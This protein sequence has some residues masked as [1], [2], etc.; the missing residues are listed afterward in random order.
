MSKNNSTR[1]ACKDVY[2]AFLVR[3]AEFEGT[4]EIPCIKAGIFKPKK[5]ISFS[6]CTS[7]REFDSWV[8]FYEDDVV[9]ERLWKN[10]GK[11]LPVLSKFE[12]VISP[13]F[14]MYRDMPLVM[15]YWNIYRNHAIAAWLQESGIKVIPNIR[16]GDERTFD[17]ACLGIEKHGTIAIGSHGCIKILKDREIFISGLDAVVQNVEP[18]IVVVYGSAPGYIFDKYREKGILILQFDSEFASS[19]KKVF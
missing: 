19:R 6:K 18:R 11:Y 4:L 16:Y 5:M 13:D 3:N 14:S 1:S 10:P 12:G 8:H 15:Q 7:A 9:F 17:S 2:N